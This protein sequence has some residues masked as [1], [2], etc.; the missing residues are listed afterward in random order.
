MKK[1]IPVMLVSLSLLS[2]CSYWREANF[3]W[4]NPF[5]AEKEE[6][7]KPVAEE[8]RVN[9]FLWQAAL[10]KTAF[11]HKAEANP[12]SGKIVTDWVS[13]GSDK[14]RLEILVNSM[15]LRADGVEVVGYKKV[16]SNGKWMEIPMERNMELAIEQSIV[17][18]AR[19][20]YARS[21][22]N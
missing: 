17:S 3:S 21:L 6:A 20:L 5:S 13:A 14:Y 11:M 8:V 7:V 15:E 19:I 10:D 18:R 9:K 12:V 22:A 1:Y 2:G 16:L 4:M